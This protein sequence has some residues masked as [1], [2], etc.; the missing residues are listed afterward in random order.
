MT[1]DSRLDSTETARLATSSRLTALVALAVFLLLAALIGRNVIRLNALENQIEGRNK[2]ISKLEESAEA[3][4][5]E[6]YKLRYA[7]EDAITVRAHA[8]AIPGI[9]ENGEQVKD[10]TIWIDLSTYRKKK[11]TR[12]SYR[13]MVENAP[14]DFRESAN[15]VNGFSISYRGTS[16]I[17]KMVIGVTFED[18][19]S[20]AI[21]FDMCQALER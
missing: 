15:A 11:L 18:G 4:K 2:T 19:T 13:V 14:F 10:F 16:C 7:P 8:E 12:V 20:E 1:A 6:V 17:S 5:N 3:L 21:D 9:I